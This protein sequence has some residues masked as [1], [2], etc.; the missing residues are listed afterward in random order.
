MPLT[1]ALIEPG[2]ERLSLQW[3]L[4]ATPA[5][6]WWGLT[7]PE[8]LPQWMG[9]ITSGKFALGNEVTVQHAENYSCISNVLDYVPEALLS[10]TW[11]F[12]DEP[13]SR[14]RIEL[15]PDR[16][17]TRL[18]LTHEGLGEETAHYLP[19]WQTHLLYLEDLLRGCPRPMTDFWST[20]EGLQN[21]DTVQA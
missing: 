10:M 8:A 17:S 5:H 2:P 18:A 7:D 3:S 16:N 4:P 19:G 9:T 13:L 14:L 21:A 6:A 1:T 12:V 11:K 20:Y 15:T